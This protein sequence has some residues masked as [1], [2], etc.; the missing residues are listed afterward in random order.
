MILPRAEDPASCPLKATRFD[1]IVWGAD[2]RRVVDGDTIDVLVE[3]PLFAIGTRVRLAGVQAPEMHAADP[4]VRARASAAKA[5]VESQIPVGAPV[6]V[7]SAKPDKYG[8]R[9]ARIVYRREGVQAD[10]SAELLAAGHARPYDGH[11]KAGD[12]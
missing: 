4:A 11:G 10:L 6:L 2:V 3:T 5:W 1:G 7:H 9:N 12:E 8:R